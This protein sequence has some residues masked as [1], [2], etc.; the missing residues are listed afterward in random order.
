MTVKVKVDGLD[1]VLDLSEYS[2]SVTDY[3]LDQ[4]EDRLPDIIDIITN[5]E[6]D[7]NYKKKTITITNVLLEL[8]NQI[9][10]EKEYDEE[11]EKRQET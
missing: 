9:V 3:V 10:E 4:F 6:I 2:S 5:A 11:R 7:Q 8:V 1:L